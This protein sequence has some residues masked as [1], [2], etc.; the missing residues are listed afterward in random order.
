MENKKSLFTDIP[1]VKEEPDYKE[2]L[3]NAL[4]SVTDIIE[5]SPVCIEF[6]ENNEYL[7]NDKKVI[8]TLGDISLF[9]GKAKQGKTFAVTMALAAAESGQLFQGK[10][11]SI[12]PEGK[13]T[14]ILFDTEQSRFYV[15]KGL[16][17]ICTLLNISEPVNLTVYCLRK[18]NPQERSD[19]IEYAICNTPN[20]GLVVIDG[21]RD[22][23]MDI[24]SSEE[25]TIMASKLL[26]WSDESMI[27][28]INILHTNKGDNNA[29]GHI[30]TELTNKAQTVL[31]VAKTKDDD[32]MAVIKPEYCRDRDFEPFGFKIDIDGLPFIVDVFTKSNP[33]DNELNSVL[34]KKKMLIPHEVVPETHK[35][36]LTE[37]FSCQSEMKWSELLIS[38]KSNLTRHLSLLEPLSDNKTKM[39]LQHWKQFKLLNQKGVEGSKSCK[40]FI[41]EQGTELD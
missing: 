7:S 40:Y 28:I 8:A 14:I 38:A 2:I 36:I 33:R 34:Q 41:D 21:I 37:I 9:I 6:I 25:S 23:I 32:P 13:K 31:S 20:L 5:A 22:L 27:H 16:K 17:R 30:G 24:N 4:V 12:L 18:Y 35:I 11:L 3:S 39:W 19:I 10:I 15:Q 1:G 29:R 26:K